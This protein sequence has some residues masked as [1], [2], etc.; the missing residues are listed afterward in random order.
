MARYLISFNNGTMDI[1]EGDLPDVAKAARA[2]VQETMDAGVYV[3]SGGL[4]LNVEYDVV[5]TDGSITDGPYPESKEHIG[6]FLIVEASTR[7]EAVEWAK[8]TASAC[9][10]PQDVREFLPD[11]FVEAWT[12]HKTR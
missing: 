7:A 2:V 9:R 12:A 3:F 10:C 4:P 11:P 1:P 8:K 5:D 6:G